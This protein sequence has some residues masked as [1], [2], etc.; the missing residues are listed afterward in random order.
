MTITEEIPA[1]TRL[2][3]LAL[4]LAYAAMLHTVTR[5]HVADALGSTPATIEE[6]AEAVEADPPTLRRLLRALALDGVFA[7]NEDGT[8]V[9]TDMSQLLKCGTP[10]SMADMVLW[11]GAA[12]TWDA[13]PR[14]I[15]AVKTGEP[16]VPD[17]YGKDFFTYLREDGGDDAQ[18]FNRAMT[19][20]SART[21]QSVVE[22]L[23]IGESKTLV[24]IGGG[25]G[26]L[27]SSLLRANPDL[28]GIL[29]DLPTV[30]AKASPELTEGGKLAART[31]FVPGDCLEAVPVDADIYLIKQVLKWD[32]DSSVKVLNNIRAAA[33]PGAR[34]VVVQNLIDDTPEPRYAAA[35]D[36]LLLLNV[37]GRE[38]T[39]AEFKSI[40]ERAGLTFA[41]VTRTSTSLRLIE[42]TV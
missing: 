6:L 17:L 12:W 34:I 15:D 38:H 30:I 23:Q 40:F 28:H 25:Q 29:F 37:G 19:Q 2:K 22:A 1:P 4:G 42:A 32:F 18:V 36:M 13:W 5:L 24:D 16:V 11:A 35:M 20:S 9:H 21:S 33:R 14:L 10:S 8:W 3:E 27:L 41:G 7:E 31:T 39:L 26:H